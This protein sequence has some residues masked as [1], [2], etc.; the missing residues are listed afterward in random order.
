MFCSLLSNLK[1]S[2]WVLDS[3][4]NITVV[5]FFPE[6][7]ICI[8]TVTD[9]K[10][11]SLVCEYNG[12]NEM[13]FSEYTGKCH[14][15]LLLRNRIKDALPQL[16]KFHLG[17]SVYSWFGFNETNDHFFITTNFWRR[18]IS[19]ESLFTREWSNGK[20]LPDCLNMSLRVL[21]SSLKSYCSF[22]NCSKVEKLL[23][24]QEAKAFSISTLL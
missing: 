5:V 4:K 19:C 12:T 6:I 18:I 8:F 16:E 3:Y 14:C 22:Q 24:L 21:L 23:K 11:N 2:P 7:R 15:L 13:L 1:P 17:L 20:W 9:S 10:Y